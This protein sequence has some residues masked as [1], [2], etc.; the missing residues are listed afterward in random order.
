MVKTLVVYYTLSWMTKKVAEKLAN[1]TGWDLKEIQLEKPITALQ[2]YAKWFFMRNS[3]N[4]PKL[5]D[6]VDISW[7]DTIYIW[8]PV[9]WYTTTPAIRS[10]L[11]DKDFSWKK[12][13]PFCTDWWNC[14]NY[15]EVMK[16]LP[17]NA[18]IWEGKE[19]QFVNRLSD[20][21]IEDIIK[22]WIK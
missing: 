16:E 14:W 18:E 3:E 13:I 10:F 20:S 11:K 21:Q 1:M 6:D 8:T 5:K 19:F 17:K 22:E 15:F 7:Y 4:P 2:A 12:V 9:W